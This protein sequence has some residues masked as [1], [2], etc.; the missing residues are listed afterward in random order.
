MTDERSKLEFT[1][2]EA[3]VKERLEETIRLEFKRELPAPGDN[4]K[5]AKVLAAMANTDGGSVIYGVEEDEDGRAKA[6]QPFAVGKAAERVTLVAGR[7]IDEPLLLPD[8]YSIV[9][10]QNAELGYL[11]VSVPRSDRAPHFVDGKAWGRTA[12]TRVTLSRRQ[13][14]ELFARTPSFAEEFGLVVGRPGRIRVVASS[15]AYQQS[16]PFEAGKIET[17][18]DYFLVFE[19]DG[20]TAVFDASWEWVPQDVEEGADASLPF[21]PNNPF[22][23]DTLPAGANV[24]VPVIFQM[25]TGALEVRTR[26]R[27]VAGNPREQTWPT[28]W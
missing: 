20:D 10:A 8:V 3:M 25:N 16:V 18:R 23:R 14:G 4:E 6:L 5:L 21:L 24:K 13:V 11:V 22:P 7:A 9:D 27:D 19:N 1:D 12:K 28:V 15:E 17:Q 2:L 26:W